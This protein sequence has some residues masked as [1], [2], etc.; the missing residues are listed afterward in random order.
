MCLWIDT[1][2]QSYIKGVYV[3]HL[4]MKHQVCVRVCSYFNFKEN[5]IF[6]ILIIYKH[7]LILEPIILCVNQ[8]HHSCHI[9][10]YHFKHSINHKIKILFISFSLFNS[11]F[12]IFQIFFPPNQGGFEVIDAFAELTEI[13]IKNTTLV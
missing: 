4:S 11:K 7:S 10:F 13:L 5:L 3:A 6:L 1:H 9:N 12:K 2:I 8:S